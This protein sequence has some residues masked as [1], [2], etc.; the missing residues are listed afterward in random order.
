MNNQNGTTTLDMSPEDAW[1]VPTVQT[2]KPQAQ[3]E[4]EA[5]AREVG[6][7]QGEITVRRNVDWQKYLQE[8]VI[9][10]LHVGRWR[11]KAALSL[12]DLGINPETPEEKQA[13]NKVINLG[14]RNLLPKNIIEAFDG[15][16]SRARGCLTYYSLDTFW[17]RY[18]HK[19]SYE[20]FAREIRK[21][22][23]EY[24][25][26][27]N[28]VFEEGFWNRMMTEVRD[29]YVAVGVQNYRR[30]QKAGVSLTEDETTWVT[31]FVNRAMSQI[32]GREWARSKVSFTWDAEYV[33]LVSTLAEDRARAAEIQA[34]QEGRVQAARISAMERDLTLTAQRK[35][36]QDLQQFVA[37]VRSDVQTRV[38]NATLDVLEAMRGAGGKL[39]PGSSK[40]L[41]SLVSQIE[42]LKFWPDEMLE[43]QFRR[44]RFELELAPKDRTIGTIQEALTKA[45][46]EAKLVLMELDRLPARDEKD[47]FLPDELGDLEKLAGRAVVSLDTV[48]DVF[49]DI[50]SGRAE[51]DLVLAL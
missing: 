28:M 41:G 13:W 1:S 7:E 8:G 50:E 43:A 42:R 36:S 38:Y 51:S 19:S 27:A 46:A 20:K 3:L 44:I 5:L 30:L 31:N 14:S 33:P 32:K 45:G 39:T 4:A 17:G 15:I 35:A 9:A 24:L 49:G 2:D 29:S 12:A 10:R 37:D 18:I 48:P 47:V 23:A 40:Q 6:A 22:K 25:D 34:A 11:A 26:L 21:L 16:E